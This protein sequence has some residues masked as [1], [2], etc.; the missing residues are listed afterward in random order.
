MADDALL[1]EKDEQAVKSVPAATKDDFEAL[2]K[3]ITKSLGDFAKEVTAAVATSRQA[4][5]PQTTPAPTETQGDEF[6]DNFVK[7]GKGTIAK[8]VQESVREMIGPWVQSQ[9]ISTADTLRDTH[10]AAVDKA[11]GSGTWDEVVAPEMEKIFSQMDNHTA[12]IARGNKATFEQVMKQARGEE[13]VMDVLAE[14]KEKMRNQPPDMLDGGRQAPKKTEFSPEDKDFM[15][16]Y[17]KKRGI[18][19]DKKALLDI[20]TKRRA[21]GGTIS[22]NDIG[23]RNRLQ[24]DG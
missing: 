23:G 7:D 8:V 24:F 13:S 3:N 11:Y 6:L 14:R 10:R 4:Q 12:T 9:V 18:S 15:Q 1:D 5:A 22:I 17:E 19:L 20:M 2:G 16:D 21:S